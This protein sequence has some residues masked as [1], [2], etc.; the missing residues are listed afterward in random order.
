V[1]P[2]TLHSGSVL[3]IMTVIRSIQ[4]ECYW[5]YAMLFASVLVIMRLD[6]RQCIS[7]RVHYAAPDAE[8]EKYLAACR[9]RGH[10]WSATESRQFPV[11]AA[12]VWRLRV[13]RANILQMA[14]QPASLY[15]FVDGHFRRC[16][17][18]KSNGKNRPRLLHA[19]P[20]G[21]YWYVVNGGRACLRA[22]IFVGL[23]RQI[24]TAINCV[25]VTEEFNDHWRV[26]ASSFIGRTMSMRPA[27]S[28][29]HA[30]TYLH[31]VH[32][33]CQRNVANV[34]TCNNIRFIERFSYYLT[35]VAI[36]KWMNDEWWLYSQLIITNLN[37]PD[38][39]LHSWS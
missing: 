10:A 37:K 36:K 9:R 18:D 38:K 14:P 31:D 28:S 13:E 7:L 21:A 33:Q 23:R 22:L 11:G 3:V 26:N 4:S 2:E 25:Y 15:V 8:I 1:E 39:K 5:P 24:E 32:R 12:S 19:S 30:N 35:F 29:L 34:N 27:I 20:G 6:T 17:A 16:T